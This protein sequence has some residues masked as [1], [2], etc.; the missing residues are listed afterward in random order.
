MRF[1]INFFLFGFIFFMIWHFFPEA[2]QTLVGWA[3]AVF[4]FF[5]NLFMQA[6]QHVNP[7]KT[8]PSTEPPK[9]LQFI[10]LFFK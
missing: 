3:N 5:R 4:D 6:S 2:F 7:P 1:I 9:V 10:G 8:P